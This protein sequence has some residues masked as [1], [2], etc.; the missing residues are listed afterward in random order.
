M[1]GFA[2]LGRIIGLALVCSGLGIVTVATADSAQAAISDGPTAIGVNSKGTSYVGFAGSG[3]L[4]RMAAGGKRLSPI[5]LDRDEAVDGI[6]ITSDDTVLVDYET[7]VQALAPGGK[8]LAEFD[9][10]PTKTCGSDHPAWK[11][12]GITFGGGRIWVANRCANTMSV[13]QR[14]GGLI[15]TVGL[16]GRPRGITFGVA[17]A[18]RPATVYVALPDKNRIV[19]FKAQNIKSSSKPVRTA[20][21]KRPSGGKVP[22]P[23][24]LAVDRYGQLTVTDLANNAVYLMDTNHD[25][26]L[27]RTLGHPPRASRSAGRL[28][29]PGA[30]AQHDQDGGSLSG[31]L[32]IADTANV[33]VQ[34]WDTG[35]YTHWAKSV[36]GSGGSGSCSSGDWNCGSNG[37]GN[38]DNGNDN[39]GNDNGGNDNGGN[40]G[41][42]DDGDDDGT[43][44]SAPTNTIAPVISGTPTVGS[45]LSCSR[46]SW[47][48]GLGSGTMSYA[49][50]WKRNGAAIASATAQ[51]YL[52]ASADSGYTLTCTVTVTNN[53]GSGSATSEGF[54]I[55][56]GGAT[57]GGPTNSVAPTITGTASVGSVLA[58]DK[59]TWSAD[60]ASFAYQWKRAGVAIAGAT[61]ASY[62]IVV[63]DAGKALT[64][65]VTATGTGG[66][67][68]ATSDAVTVGATGSAPANSAVPTITGDTMPGNVVTCDRGTWSGSPTG[69]SYQWRSNGTAIARATS[70]SYTLLSQDVSTT[71]T[72]VVTAT[73]AQGAASATSAGRSVAGWSGHGASNVDPPSITG[74]AAVGQTL[75]CAP[76]TWSG[77]PT[78]TTATKWQRDGADISGATNASYTVASADL[79]TVLTCLVTASNGSGKAAVAVSTGTVTSGSAILPAVQSVPSIT[80]P[81]RIGSA[82]TCDKGSW[83]GADIT[84]R[85]QWSRDGAAIADTNSATYLVL[86]DDAGKSLTCTVTATNAAGSASYTT[87]AR[88]A[89]PLT[90]ST[91]VATVAPW[92]TGTAATG[93]T[94][95]CNRGTWTAAS[96][97]T[98]LTIWQRDGVTVANGSSTYVLTAADAGASV[99]C[100]VLASISGSPPGRPARRRWAATA[101]AA[102]S[103]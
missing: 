75:T 36:S 25:F 57:T 64:C 97:P 67:T 85:Y 11:Y 79:G 29:T 91:P 63:D 32:F 22:V 2:P 74:T 45:T 77:L 94:L 37:G 88:T 78:I 83:T 15:A 71:L 103:A 30:I 92:I 12:G 39:G 70:P 49:F 99:R 19:A 14:N 90:G 38:D 84:Y 6:F 10:E 81:P 4:V 52:V 55:T 43:S 42:D 87:A 40:N 9:H 59:G 31:N 5:K 95:T 47:A 93:Q 34:R 18:G 101:A 17:Q 100:V 65:A 58:C 48:A 61:S 54:P 28:N 16:S 50:Q 21:I 41:G 72:C 82:V 86:G 80:S 69:Y 102:P 56:G 51:T 44:G 1:R 23:G 46:G 96:T 73:N 33:R 3:K 89:D 8:V 62:T 98:Y 76:G 20:A 7:G 26:S 24:G 66:S 53:S 35:G 68:T 60:A 27:Y 13:Y